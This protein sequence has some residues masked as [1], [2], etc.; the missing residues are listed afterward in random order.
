MAASSLRSAQHLH[1]FE[2]GCVVAALA[3]APEF[4][5]VLVIG[6]VTA[7]TIFRHFYFFS[8]FAVAVAAWQFRVR[9]SQRKLRLFGVIELR[10]LPTFGAVAG[11]A[12]AA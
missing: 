11:I 9:T 3:I 6:G 1:L 5:V 10:T 7:I 12:T 4:A 8:R 2:I